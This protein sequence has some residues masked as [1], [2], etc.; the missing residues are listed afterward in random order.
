MQLAAAMCYSVLVLLRLSPH[1]FKSLKAKDAINFSI[2]HS[3]YSIIFSFNVI[4]FE[5]YTG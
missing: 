1:N 2:S 3:A 5:I 4:Q